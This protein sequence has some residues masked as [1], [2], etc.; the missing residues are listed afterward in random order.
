MP[1]PWFGQ[2]IPVDNWL[3]V[4]VPGAV[5]GWEALH[6]RFGR[7]PLADLLAPAIS[8]AEDGF[9]VSPLIARQV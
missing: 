2:D 9:G 6:Q 5:A 8:Y 1:L 3:P 4:T 7:L